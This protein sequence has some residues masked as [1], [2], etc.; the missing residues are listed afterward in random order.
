V[1]PIRQSRGRGASKYRVA[2]VVS[3]PIQYQAPLLR[4]LAHQ[5]DLEVKTFFLTDAGARP[6]SDRGFGRVVQWDIPLLEGYEHEFVAE[7]LPLPL[8]FDQPA[9]FPWRRAF[10]TGSFNAVWLHGYAHGPL[11]RAFAA[12]K[13][14]GLK[15]IIRG[16]S[17]D[18]LREKEP[19]WRLAA[20]R[21]LFRRADRFLAIG[22]ANRDFY[23]ARGVA[24][25]QIHMAPYAVDNGYFRDLVAAA[26]PCRTTKLRELGL[27]AD[28]PIILFASKLQ[29]RKRCSDLLRAYELI[30]TSQGP[31]AQILVVGDGPEML[32]LQR[33][34]SSR[35]LDDVH[36]LGFKNQSELPSFYDLCDV[37]VL[38][39]AKE[40]WGLVVNEAMN[41]GKPV[42]VSDDVGAARDLV[43]HGKTGFVFPV[44]D[45][46]GLASC[47]DALLQDPDLRHRMGA[48]AQDTVSAWGLDATVAGIRSAINALAP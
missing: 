35:A 9:N 13:S 40:P 27:S 37:F 29:E 5:P 20:Q 46:A 31:R 12:A 47:L 18:G 16:E 3:H 38:P 15:V 1:A 6:F 4:Q 39:S 10:S 33:Y 22:S 25:D 32:N 36:F 2:Y 7:G 43:H 17:R 41:A 23:L 44:G 8:A 21:F 11:L 28:I 30:R 45:V 19:L 24:P 48:A 26:R 42:V 34:A 14:L